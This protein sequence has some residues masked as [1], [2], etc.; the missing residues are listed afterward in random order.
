MRW[1]ELFRD[2][3]G[4]L[5][6]AESADLAAEA[7][8]RTRREAAR[9]TVLDRARGA[10]GARV[11][12]QVL[13]AGRI[14]GVLLQVGGGWL[15]VGESAGRQ[16]LVPLPAVL[17]LSGMSVRSAGAGPGGR[18][19]DRLGLGHALRGLARDRATVSVMLI[20]GSTRAG[21]V[22]RVGADFLELHELPAGEVRGSA[23][24]LTVPVA[25]VALVR[26]A[27]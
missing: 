16:A 9:L 4:Q 6:A 20:D 22:D 18:V 13:G 3:E 19:L 10:L 7:A 21:T 25:A 27:S 1:D 17:A 23:G 12:V 8:D 26:S 11:L 5:E 14:D 24:L 2:L 15:L